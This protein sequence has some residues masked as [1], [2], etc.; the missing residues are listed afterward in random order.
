MT[1][2]L[3]ELGRVCSSFVKLT[4]RVLRPISCEAALLGDICRCFMAQFITHGQ[5]NMF[6]HYQYMMT[7]HARLEPHPVL[8]CMT[9]IYDIVLL[10]IIIM[11]NI[12]SFVNSIYAI[13]STEYS[14]PFLLLLFRQSKNEICAFG[15][16]FLLR[17]SLLSQARKRH[18][19]HKITY[20]T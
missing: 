4:K 13:A 11:Y 17:R 14:F 3:A 6:Q 9:I 7:A 2:C 5:W 8:L 15:A 12:V 19:P 20:Y 10:C 16:A 1:A 18:Y